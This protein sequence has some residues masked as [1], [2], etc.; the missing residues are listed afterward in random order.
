[1]TA[2]G[3]SPSASEQGLPL[4]QYSIFQP[5]SLPMPGD[6]EHGRDTRKAAMGRTLVELGTPFLVTFIADN[7]Q[8]R[9]PEMWPMVEP[10]AFPLRSHI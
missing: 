1:M 9:G 8:S 4:K 3:E 6:L 2:S 10:I 5:E 7:E